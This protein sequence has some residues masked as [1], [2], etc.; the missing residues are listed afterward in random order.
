MHLANNLY[1]KGY[2]PTAGI[3]QFIAAA[4]KLACINSAAVATP[5]C[6]AL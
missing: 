6:G 5:S 4:K 3:P 1:S 2:P